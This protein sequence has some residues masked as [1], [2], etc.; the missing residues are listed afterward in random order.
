MSD[1]VIIASSD[2]HAGLPIR[3]YRDYLD[4]RYRDIFDQAVGIEIERIQSAEKSFLIKEINDEWRAGNEKPL[5]GAWD[6]DERIKVLDK[7]G[8]AVEVVFPD[9]ITEINTPPFGAGLSLPTK[10][11]VPEL[12][13]AGARAH[14]RWLV[15]FFSPSAVRHIPVAVVPLLWDVEEAIGEV[16]RV[17][18]EGIRSVLIPA[19]WGEMDAYHHPKYYPFWEACQDL[20]VVVN[21][22]SGPGPMA[23]FFGKDWPLEQTAGLDGAMGLYVGEVFWWT[24]R[25][26]AFML[27]GGVFERYPRLKVVMTETG[28]NWMLQPWLRILDYN[29]SDKAFSAKLGDFTSHLSMKPSDYFRRNVALGASCIPRG[30]IEIRHEVGVDLLMWGSDY[31]HPEG[32]WP[33]TAAALKDAFTGFPE[34]DV[35]AIL[36]ENLLRF[37]G[38]DRAAIAPIAERIGPSIKQFAA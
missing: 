16:R 14:N 34:Q 31:P 3:R 38:L 32:S 25:P 19:M 9:G 15:E 4:S 6:Y 37:Y 23:D 1:K 8:I 17:H 35:R 18:A 10:D 24:Y 5:S 26:L 28:T 21:F 36:G 30:D 11:I 33:N 20:G 29:Y 13:W 7:D 27:W 12:Q 2:C 22:H